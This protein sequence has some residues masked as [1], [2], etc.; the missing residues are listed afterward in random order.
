M[1]KYTQQLLEQI[2]SKLKTCPLIYFSREVER[3]L[4]LEELLENYHI[5][6]VEDHYI[7]DQLMAKGFD[8]FCIDKY[9]EQLD[10]NSTINLY[11]HPKTQEW[12]K[13][14]SKTKSFYSQFF[15]IFGPLMRSVTTQSGITL[16]NPVLVSRMFE[17]KLSQLRMLQQN[18]VPLPKTLIVELKDYLYD[19]LKE[20]LGTTMV[21][22]L[23]KAHTGG[24][25]FVI[26]SEEEW[27]KAVKKIRGTQAKVAEFIDGEAYTINGCVTNKGIYIS[28]LQYQITG[29]PELTSGVGTTVGNDWSYVSCDQS[30]INKDLLRII[31]RI[32]NMMQQDDYRGLFGVDLILKGNLWYVIEINARQTA[33]IPMQSKL[34]I[35]ADRVP[36]ALINLAEFL[37]IEIPFKPFSEIYPLEGSQVFLRAKDDNFKINHEVKSGVYRLQGDNSAMDWKRAISIVKE[38]VIFIDE[39]KDKPLIWQHDGYSINHVTNGGFVVLSQRKD[40][41]KSKHEE[42][43]RFQFKNQIVHDGKVAPWILEAMK[44]IEGMM[45]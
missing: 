26:K 6:C 33:N 17:D 3:A 43:L 5:A 21:I 27:V 1:N 8:V 10:K 14:I 37:N 42:L 22:Q 29:V 31:S 35:L 30:V 19:S 44:S 4:G 39:E 16:N 15:K 18:N 23:D 2:N 28:G 25:T 12:I 20:E 40:N 38:D 24:G 36:L 7:V 13:K 32:G 34:E 41:I 45:K 9:E 11:N